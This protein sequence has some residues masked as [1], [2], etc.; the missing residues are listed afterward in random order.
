MRKGQS[1]KS[2]EWG[3]EALVEWMLKSKGVSKGNIRLLLDSTEQIRVAWDRDDR[4]TKGFPMQTAGLLY[5]IETRLKGRRPR[6]RRTP[7][8][9]ILKEPTRL[10]DILPESTVEQVHE[11][12][13]EEPFREALA[14]LHSADHRSRALNRIKDTIDN[15][16]YA[17]HYGYETLPKP[18]GN[19]LHRQVLGVLTAVAPGKLSDSEMVNLFNYFC[20]CGTEHNREAMKKFRWRL[21]RAHG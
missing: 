15:A 18:R 17:E 7:R 13:H 16:L 8:G 14:E 12:L 9:I 4:G 1:A 21:S 19:W 10:S 2:K 11:Y 20:P 5:E 6:K 3:P